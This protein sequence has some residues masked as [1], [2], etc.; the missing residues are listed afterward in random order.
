MRVNTPTT[1][2]APPH[3]S[4]SGER[5]KF[6]NITFRNEY[7]SKRRDSVIIHIEIQVRYVTFGNIA[8]RNN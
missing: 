3:C 8:F 2:L 6:A 5:F 1:R 7:I 4:D